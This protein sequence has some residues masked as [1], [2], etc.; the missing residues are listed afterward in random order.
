MRRAGFGGAAALFTVAVGARSGNFPKS[1]DFSKSFFCA[2]VSGE[3]EDSRYRCCALDLNGIAYF[4][5]TVRP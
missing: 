4:T 3:A 1:V 2:A 5:S